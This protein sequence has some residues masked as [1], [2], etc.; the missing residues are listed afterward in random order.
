MPPENQTNHRV[1]VGM[2][3]DICLSFPGF[4]SGWLVF[5]RIF[6][7]KIVT[8]STDGFLFFGWGRSTKTKQ[9]HGDLRWISDQT[10]LW[11]RSQVLKLTKLYSLIKAQSFFPGLCVILGSSDSHLAGSGILSVAINLWS[12]EEWAFSS[13]HFYAYHSLRSYTQIIRW[14]K[15]ASNNTTKSLIGH[16][17]MIFI[18]C[19]WKGK[20]FEFN[21]LGRKIFYKSF[22]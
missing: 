15:I 17:L 10:F 12:Q 11:N 7:P 9:K 6:Y 16:F 1:V 20:D 19:L 8:P 2:K 13:F 18:E 22:S 14:S 4:R 3:L 5:S 21:L